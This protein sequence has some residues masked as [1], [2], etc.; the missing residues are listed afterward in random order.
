MKAFWPPKRGCDRVGGGRQ[1]LR[2]STASCHVA[3]FAMVTR[4]FHVALGADRRCIVPRG[5]A[6]ALEN[7]RLGKKSGRTIAVKRL[8]GK[9]S[10]GPNMILVAETEKPTSSDPDARAGNRDDIRDGRFWPRRANDQPDRI[11]GG[12]VFGNSHRPP[13]VR[14]SSRRCG[15]GA[16]VSDE[17]R[18]AR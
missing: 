12:S 16:K 11:D 15:P 14:A 3:R 6:V 5:M 13:P 17:S 10:R 4:G 18:E 9:A 2:S 1:K 8:S 7:H